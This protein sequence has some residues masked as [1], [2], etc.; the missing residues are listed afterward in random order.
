MPCALCND[1]G[2]V[3]TD[4]IERGGWEVCPLCYPPVPARPGFFRRLWRRFLA[5]MRFD[6]TA[7]C[8]ESVGRGL[9]DDYHDYPDSEAGEPWHFVTL[10]CKRCGKEFTI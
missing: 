8:E 7:V 2:M 3:R 10:R 9:T 5:R 6:L 1:V 4:D